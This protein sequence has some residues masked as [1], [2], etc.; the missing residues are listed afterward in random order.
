MSKFDGSLAAHGFSHHY[1]YVLGEEMLETFYV[2]MLKN[3]LTYDRVAGYFSST[4]LSHASAG[5]AEFCKSPNP[6]ESDDPR[7]HQPKFRLIVGARL[8]PRDEQVVLHAND[9]TLLEEVEESLINSIE[10]LDLDDEID[11]NRN[12]FQGLSWMLKNGLLEMKVGARYIPGSNQLLPHDE[13]EFHAKY[14]IVSDGENEMYFQGSVNET[15]RGWLDNFEDVNVSRS[16]A[17]EESRLNIET[18]KKKFDDL[19]NDRRH[20][21]GV[22]VVDFPEAARQKILDKFK[23]RDPSGI[24]EVSDAKKRRQMLE[25]I[26]GMHEGWNER[27][28]DIDK[29]AHQGK[30]KEWFLDED[31]ANGIGILE[32]A[33]GSGKTRTALSIVEEAVNS[34]R[35]E[36]TVICVPK[37]LEEQWYM[38]ICEH[39]S[40][41]SSVRWWKSGLD[42]HVPFFRLDRRGAV[43]IV[44]HY[45]I[46]DLFEYVNDNA[47][48]CGNVLLIVD[49]MHRLGSK[50]YVNSKIIEVTGE[51][52]MIEIRSL[53]TKRCHPFKM[54][55]GLS[56]TPWSEYDTERNAFLAGNFVNGWEGEVITSE[57]IEVLRK[58]E[59]IFTFGL[60]EA[61]EKGILCEFDYVPLP[62]TPSEEDFEKRK[63]AFK[64]IPPNAPE[65]FGRML[66][67]QVFKGSREKLP[68]FSSW[69][70]GQKSGLSRC[71]IFVEDTSFGRELNEL[72]YN[73]HNLDRFK[74]FFQGEDMGTLDSF[75][76]GRLDFLIACDRISEGIDIKTVDTIVLFSCDQVRLQTIQRIG[77]ALRTLSTKQDKR[78]TVVDF[79]FEEEGKED[80]SDMLR[81]AWLEELSNTRR[82]R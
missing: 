53:D 22:V 35:V 41:H 55:L 28:T 66:A 48:R 38:E 75:A 77:R 71:I 37:S 56:A 27:Y 25:S 72:L 70:H 58:E 3:S 47:S 7:K 18:Y 64:K 78:A 20:A 17:G 4:V 42:E 2:P 81:K 19:W 74:E 50:K 45:F 39:Y 26:G 69:L 67:A 54:R 40:E 15:K 5:F 32:M 82:K 57:Q 68:V 79:Y 80:S 11:F 49:E 31:S 59:K 1:D 14:G 21:K 9:P 23:P 8:N 12:R 63:K 65:W 62:Y 76:E 13:A 16:W 30:A 34:D 10:N 33:T 46:P 61:I 29:W 44:S 6:R 60:K 24:N 43:L 73:E 52:E 51:E 36:K